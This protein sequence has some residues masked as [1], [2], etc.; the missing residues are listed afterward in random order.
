MPK[1][2]AE[3]QLTQ[4]NADQYLEEEGDQEEV[5]EVT[6]VCLRHCFIAFLLLCPSTERPFLQSEP[7]VHKQENVR[8]R[9]HSLSIVHFNI[10]SIPSVLVGR[11]VVRIFDRPFLRTRCQKCGFDNS[12]Q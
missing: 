5:R 6:S 11:Q 10:R 2:L 12:Q 7:G 1:R 3:T 9:L 8:E 4:D